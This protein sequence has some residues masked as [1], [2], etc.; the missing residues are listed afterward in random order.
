VNR[1]R[2]KLSTS[3]CKRASSS[4]SSALFNFLYVPFVVHRRNETGPGPSTLRNQKLSVRH[5][6]QPGQ[7]SF[8]PSAFQTLFLRTTVTIQDM[9]AVLLDVTRSDLK[10]CTMRLS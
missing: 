9:H 4:S 10:T 3:S 2:R 1:Q 7:L 6:C 8:Y 5:H